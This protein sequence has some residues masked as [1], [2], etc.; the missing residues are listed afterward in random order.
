M[1]DFFEEVAEGIGFRL[2]SDFSRKL[3]E[4]LKNIKSDSGYYAQIGS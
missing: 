1:F 4:F 2:I 3:I